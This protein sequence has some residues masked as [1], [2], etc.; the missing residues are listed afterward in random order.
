MS[1]DLKVSKQCVQLVTMAIR[2][3]GMIYRSFVYR[4]SENILPL[5]RPHLLYCVQAWCPYL[6][7]G[8]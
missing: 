4:T 3:L 8:H 7:K 5:V 2:V 6:E 1:G